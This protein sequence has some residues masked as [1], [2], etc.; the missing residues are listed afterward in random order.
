VLEASSL[1]APP[2]L[3]EGLAALEAE[4]GPGGGEP[5]DERPVAEALRR[6][7]SMGVRALESGALDATL[8][9]LVCT[10]AEE[11]HGAGAW[12]RLLE[13]YSRG[14]KS[15]DAFGVA[16]GRSLE[17][18]DAAFRRWMEQ[19]W[20]RYRFPPPG[21]AD[22]DLPGALR[23]GQA[24]VVAD[25][26]SVE[27]HTSYGLALY[28]D[29]RR[30]EA[31][32]HLRTGADDY[33]TWDTL[34]RALADL[35]RWGEAADAFR[36]AA[37]CIPRPVD[38]GGPG[39]NVYRRLNSA[40]LAV[41]DYRG[42][43]R[44]LQGM[45]TGDPLDVEDRLKLARL[46]Q[47][48]GDHAG[49]RAVLAEAA[50]VE[51]RDVALYDLGAACYRGLKEYGGAVEMTLRAVALVEERGE[52]TESTEQAERFCAVG[53]DHLAQGDKA[54]ALEYAREALRRVSGLERARRLFEA[55]QG[56]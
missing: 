28:R 33:Q 49:M 35:D 32:N 46:L 38:D 56:K 17:D 18:F 41:K 54:R 39:E 27:A 16:F 50:A 10:F 51:V 47:E 24:A 6:N 22:G 31:I 42:A 52:G 55:C 5:W 34:G 44:A 9:A 13:A 53:E 2:W 45:L 30:D 20:S 25:P 4:R 1:R 48:E 23:S 26:S 37:A 3:V 43:T 7:L 14:A 29:G 36:R 40:L 11:A 19:R 15:A 8:A 21:G 12:A